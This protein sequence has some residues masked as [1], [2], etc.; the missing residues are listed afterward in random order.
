MQKQFNANVQVLSE[1]AN[2]P[3]EQTEYIVYFQSVFSQVDERDI[4]FVPEKKKDYVLPLPMG[5]SDLGNQ[6]APAWQ[7][8]FMRSELKNSESTYV[9]GNRAVGFLKFDTSEKSA[10]NLTSVIFTLTDASKRSYDFEFNVIA[11][12]SSGTCT[13]SPLLICLDVNND[14]SVST[15]SNQIAQQVRDKINAHPIL[16]TADIPNND[17]VVRLIQDAAEIGNT[18]I[19]I[20]VPTKVH[21]SQS[22]IL[23]KGARHC[24]S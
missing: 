19:A 24:S 6:K 11:D 21:S 7:I 5:T 9:D 17:G 12:P 4:A 18:T 20:S 3:V 2:T 1:I 22:M 23:L 13:T 14:N 10:N 8:N 15:T 16:I